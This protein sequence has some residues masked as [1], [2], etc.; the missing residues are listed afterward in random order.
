MK[1]ITSEHLRALTN[2]DADPVDRA[3][4]LTALAHWEKG[5]YDHLEPTIAGLI[6][7]PSPLVRGAAIQTLLSG[8]KRSK[9]LQAAIDML[10]GDPDD[11]WTAR[12]DAAFALA[13]FAIYGGT[14]RE[15]IIRELVRALR[16]DRAQAVQEQCYEQILRIVAPDRDA[17]SVDE[18]DRDRDVDWELLKPY[19]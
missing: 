13:Q 9:Y 1:Q 19:L 4:A 5:K 18:F 8:W 2:D 17:P 3:E 15:R 14:D 10:H 16:E 6:R 11:D 12:H 7:D